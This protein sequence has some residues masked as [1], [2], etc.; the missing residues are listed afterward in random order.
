MHPNE[1]LQIGSF[2]C[3]LLFV[4]LSGF[5]RK[6]SRYQN[7]KY[8]QRS[9]Y[10]MYQGRAHLSCVIVPAT[11]ENSDTS[12]LWT[13]TASWGSRHGTALWHWNLLGWFLSSSRRP[14]EPAWPLGVT[15][16]PIKRSHAPTP[17]TPLVNITYLYI[18]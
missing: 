12:S 10:H 5:L 18:G 2:L 6:P 15:C 11:F 9:L 14:Q 17:P 8:I 1:R 3:S 13:C 7:D 16:C 4:G